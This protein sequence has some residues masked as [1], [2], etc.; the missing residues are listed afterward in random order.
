M[1]TEDDLDAFERTTFFEGKPLAEMG[2][3]ELVRVVRFL[4][5]DQRRPPLSPTEEIAPGITREVISS[6]ARLDKVLKERERAWYGG[7]V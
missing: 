1:S 7:A 3:S 6:L 5:M 4:S 2:R